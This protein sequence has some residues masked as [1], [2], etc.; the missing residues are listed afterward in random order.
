M[1]VLPVNN[2]LNFYSNVK[3]TN[4]QTDNKRT[5][6]EMVNYASIIGL[7]GLSTLLMLDRTSEI[8]IKKLLAKKEQDVRTHAGDTTKL[9]FSNLK[10]NKSVMSLDEISGLDNLK[11][12]V[13]QIDILS[14][15]KEVSKEHKIENSVSILLWGLPGTGK[16]TAAKGIAKKLDADFISLNK[17]LFDSSYVSEGPRQLSSYL[18]SIKEYS[19]NNPNKKIVV[20]MDEI[21]GTISIDNGSNT[22]HS[23]DLVNVMKRYLTDLQSECDNIIFIG[24]TNK[25]PNGLKSDNTAIKLNNAILSRF[26]YQFEIGLPDENAVFDAWSK[27][28][29]TLSGKEKFTEKQNKLISETFNKLGMSYRDI[30][31]I[32]DKLNI[33][34]AVEFCKKGSYN[35]KTNLIY[36]LQNDEKIGYDHIKKANIDTDLKKK[37]INNLENNI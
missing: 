26:N 22:R 20:F 15:N 9:V 6:K 24:A 29:K 35:S 33:E 28:T 11:K 31:N 4:N 25:D 23:E 19:K 8:R 37:I 32:S 2:N 36:A 7:I 13:N 17:E 5:K 1:K 30:K 34:D 12:F 16:T 21:D 3:E 18:E 27:L 14:K 10:N